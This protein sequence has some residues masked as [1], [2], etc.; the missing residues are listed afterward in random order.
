T[1]CVLARD[2]IEPAFDPALQSEIGRVY[3]E[4]Q[5]AVDDAAIEP[6]GQDELHALHAPVAAGQL[7]PLIEPGE[8][9]T[10]PGFALPN[11]GADDGGLQPGEGGFE[12]LV[13]AGAGLAAYGREQVIGGEAQETRGRKAEILRLD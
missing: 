11:G 1:P 13:V 10:T 5:R 3:R 7:F 2:A 6:V 12:Q 8:L 4:H 9:V